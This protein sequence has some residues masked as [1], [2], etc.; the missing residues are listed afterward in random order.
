M[1]T[2]VGAEECG[3]ITN[4]IVRNAGGHTVLR[5]KG[6]TLLIGLSVSTDRARVG[7]EV[8]GLIDIV[9]Y[10]TRKYDQHDKVVKNG[11]PP[12]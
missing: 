3:R 6:T 7:M 10:Y 12:S 5:Y 8:P 1:G 4:G 2:L 9:L 11:G